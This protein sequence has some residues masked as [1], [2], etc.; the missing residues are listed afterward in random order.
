[1]RLLPAIKLSSIFSIKRFFGLMLKMSK[2][3][4][5]GS[6][7]VLL[8]LSP[9][10][11]ADDNATF[12]STNTPIADFVAWGAR[13]LDR[14]IV[15]GQGVIGSVSFTAP[16]LQPSEYAAF[17]NNVLTAHGYW[18]QYENNLYVVKP[19]G[20]EEEHIEPSLI[21]LYRLNHVRNTKILTLLS[22]TLAAS[23][24]KNSKGE[25]ARN[26]NVEALPT[27]NALIVTGSAEQF[28]KIDALVSGIDQPQ[29]QVFIEAVITETLLDNSKEVGVNMNVALGKA[30]FVTNTTVLDLLTDNAAIYSGGDFKALVKAVSTDQNTKLLSRPNM[31]IMD[32]E[33]GYITVGQNVPFLTSTEV[34]DGGNVIQQI[35]RK[36]VGVSLEVVPHIIGGE[37]VLDIN[38]E[39]Q[40]VSNSSIASDI[41]TNKRT[42]KTVVKV[43]DKQT[44]M[45]GGLI[46]NDERKT[47]SGVPVLMDIPYLG[48]LFRSDKMEKTQRELRIVIRTTVL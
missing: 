39:S 3:A 5:R 23:Q 28:K 43:K 10:C 9:I 33:R 45:L 27:T 29:R 22:T 44:I 6:I 15:L 8:I 35:E 4:K 40:S 11:F 37:I 42:L 2:Q 48:A 36:D 17:F 32:R 16:N 12:E 38:Q 1:M 25:S 14:P 30:G 13:K 21:K 47:V 24:T 41:I 46:S 26:F 20:P 19:K 31:L 34:T 7:L 18:I